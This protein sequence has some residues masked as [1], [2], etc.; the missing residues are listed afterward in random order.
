MHIDLRGKLTLIKRI[1]HIVLS[2]SLA[3]LLVFGTTAKEFLHLFADHTDTVHVHHAHDGLVIE[4]EHHHCSFLTYSLSSFV[5][6][7]HISKIP[8]VTHE[9][10]QYYHAVTDQLVVF[11]SLTSFL[12]GPPARFV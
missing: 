9:Y 7:F 3:V 2:A 10:V 1:I 12:R 5:N 6:D 11:S 4:Q 8:Y